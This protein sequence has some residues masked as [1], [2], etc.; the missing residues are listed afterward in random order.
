MKAKG[1][2]A[3]KKVLKGLVMTDILFNP[4]IFIDDKIY[5]EVQELRITPTDPKAL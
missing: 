3:F 4:A 5:T 2:S 1:V